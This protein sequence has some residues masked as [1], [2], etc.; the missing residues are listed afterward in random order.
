MRSRALIVLE[1]NGRRAA[2]GGWCWSIVL[3]RCTKC[4]LC[5]VLGEPGWMG[6]YETKERSNACSGRGQAAR[7]LA[8]RTV[9]RETPLQSWV[10]PQ[11]LACLTEWMAVVVPVGGGR[12]RSGVCCAESDKGVDVSRW[13][14]LM[15]AFRTV[16]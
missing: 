3:Q 5:R 6:N 10:E 1:G 9:D 4:R 16:E 2:W 8:G 15:H 14:Q 7:G 11:R 13:Q 12:W